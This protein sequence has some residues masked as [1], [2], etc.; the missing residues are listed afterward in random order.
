MSSELPADV[1][2]TVARI[3]QSY[4]NHPGY[5]HPFWEWMARGDYSAEK[6][7]E[8]ALLY[9]GHVRY[10]RQYIARALSVVPEESVQ[11]ALAQILSDEYGLSGSPSHPELFRRFMRSLSL[12]EKDWQ[13]S[14]KPFIGIREFRD[15]HFK[16]FQEEKY[17]ETMGAVVFGFESTTP[18]RHARVVEGLQK[19]TERTGHNVDATFFSEHVTI[20]PHHSGSLL[21]PLKGMLQEEDNVQK[22][23]RGA[24]VSFDARKACLDSLARC[25][26]A[27]D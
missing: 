8:F 27:Q 23:I 12:E 16:L 2:A 3:E 17:P 15:R 4:K 24:A 18:Y 19:F 5:R 10:F 9:Y 25:L 26:G 22:V 1:A 20:D 11:I 13:R 21:L 14:A 7:R 6:L